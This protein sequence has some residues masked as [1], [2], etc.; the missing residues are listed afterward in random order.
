MFSH[1][2]KYDSTFIYSFLMFKFTFIDNQL[3]FFLF[4]LFIVH[5]YSCSIFSNMSNSFYWYSIFQHHL[6]RRLFSLHWIYVQFI[7]MIIVPAPFVEKTL[8]SPLNCIYTLLKSQLFRTQVCM[9][10]FLDSLVCSVDQFFFIPISHWYFVFY[11][12]WLL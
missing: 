3:Y 11:S 2:I 9:G 1:D 4:S 10:L 7:L 6:L 12:S 8:L 5:F